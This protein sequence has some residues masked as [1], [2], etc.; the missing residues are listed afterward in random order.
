MRALAAGLLS[1]QRAASGVPLLALTIGGVDYLSKI[2]KV[3]H[4]ERPFGG[5]ATLLLDNSDG[6]ITDDLRGDKVVISYGFS[7]EGTSTAPPLWV[8]SQVDVSQEGVLLTQ[9]ICLDTWQKLSLLRVIGGGGVQL[10]GTIVGSFQAGMK[11]TGGTSGATAT[12]LGVGADFLWITKVANGP[13][14]VAEV[15]SA[16]LASSTQITVSAVTDISGGSEPNWNGDKTILEIIEQLTS[17][18]VTVT[19]DSSDGIIDV[20]KPTFSTESGARITSIIQDLINYTQCAARMEGDEKLH[21]FDISSAPGAPDYTY[22]TAHAFRSDI[23]DVSLILPNKI[24]VVN[25]EQ[26]GTGVTPFFG[27]AEDA[28][29][30]A[31][32]TTITQL[33]YADVQSNDDATELATSRL[34]RIKLESVRGTI[35][36]PMNCGQE[37]FDYVRVRDTRA[38]L[39]FY[40]WVGSLERVWEEGVYKLTIGLG[41]LMGAVGIPSDD[42]Y[43]LPNF[44]VSVI[45]FPGQVLPSPWVIPAA[46]QGYHHDLHFVADD[47]NTVS[48]GAG[49]IKFYD[50]TEQ[51]IDAGSYDIPNALVH[52][53]Y[54]DLNDA[55]PEVLKTTSNY[56]NVL[57][58][59]TGVLCMIQRGSDASVNATVIPSYGKEPL[60]TADVIYLAGLLDK[61]PDGTYG[62]TLSTCISAG[63]ILL[64]E[65]SGDIDDIGDGG[66]YAKVKKTDISAGHIKLTVDQDLDEQGIE[67]ISNSGTYKIKID[68]NYVAGYRGATKT[69]YLRASD[70]RAYCGGGSVILDEDGIE[71]RG[72]T[73][74]RF[75]YSGSHVASIL[76]NVLGNLQL[77][78]AAGYDTVTQDFFATNLETYFHE[79]GNIGYIDKAWRYI[80]GKYLYSDGGSIYS[81]Q[82][83]DD[84]ELL[85]SIRSKKSREGKDVIDADSLPT[86][87]IERNQDDPEQ[88]YVNVAGL[89]G[90]SIGIMKALL[91]KIE[92]LE[93]RV[94]ALSK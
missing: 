83:R 88:H 92:V 80:F 23:R 55:S 3:T 25:A 76:V 90:L 87:L 65:T 75:S 82:E 1:A 85:K 47:Y 70:G 45:P 13:F 27:E 42:E 62:K 71:I 14:T 81:Y 43:P 37:L 4:A 69:F 10:D 24:I 66:T 18:I 74:L 63:R 41:G 9:L 51:S 86:E 28:A 44:P 64:E 60:I 56:L 39:D 22:D 79:S 77:S 53:I 33:I 36:V 54:F 73:A 50:G 15:V 68:S 84:I 52:H 46:V 29:A 93:E 8:L 67:I 58:T 61:L 6:S 20:T 19:K 2:K 91:D 12:V 40:G 57:S 38:D 30:I 26:I 11:I 34:A 78:P 72:L 89:H 31:R 32:F 48:W 49:T 5:S 17:G 59:K 35:E 21:I 7:G 16:D 94:N